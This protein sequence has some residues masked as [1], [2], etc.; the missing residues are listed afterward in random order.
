MVLLFISITISFILTLL[1]IRLR[2]SYSK[3]ALDTQ[4][5]PQKVHTRPV[6]RIGGLAIFT[7]VT[8]SILY[9]HYFEPNDSSFQDLGLSLIFCAI[10]TFIV[11]FLED[12]TKRTGILIR[13]LGIIFSSV[14]AFYF[15]SAQISDLGIPGTKA[16]LM[17]PFFCLI[18]T[19]FS[20]TG[21]T[22]SYNLIDGFNGLASMVGI[23]TLGSISYVSF[24]NSD[25]TILFL[26]AIMIGAIIGFFI[27]NYPNGLIF[28]G[29]AGAYFIGFYI[30]VLSILLVQRHPNISPFYALVVNAYPI[31]ET[32][33]TI[34]R[35]RVHR[36][37]KSMMPDGIHFHTLIYRRVMRWATRDENMAR[38]NNAR[39][40]PYLWALSCMSI[41]PAT[42]WWDDG[43]YLII[44]ILGFCIFYIL[45]YRWIV[46]F[47]KI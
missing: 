11:G 42:L 41:V 30:A 19:L 24:K 45:C 16:L 43:S 18:L 34:W 27:W 23:L 38:L 5:G 4:S 15:L 37:R 17:I 32:L 31:F 36:G 25:S 44:A 22:N 21:L 1:L 29:D 40:S 20:I 6:S 28:L 12:V 14:L 2:S 10:P 47:K 3:Y 8:L 13:M 7:S 39:T 33:F 9:R 35:R 26:S 46:L